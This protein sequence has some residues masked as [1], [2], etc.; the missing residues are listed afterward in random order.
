MDYREGYLK[1]RQRLLSMYDT[2]EVAK[3]DAWISSL[4]VDD[5]RASLSDL[6]PHCPLRP[7]MTVLDAGAGTG[8]LCIMLSLVPGLQITALE[9]CNAMLDRLRGKPEI[10]GIAVHQGF[11]D[12]LADRIHFSAGSF[13][14]IASRQL[15]NTLFDPLSAF[16][17]WH[18][19]L[20]HGGSVIVMDGLFDRESWPDPWSDLVDQLP[21]S[22]CRTMATVP[23]LLEKCGFSIEYVG[24]MERTNEMPSTRTKRYMVVARKPKQPV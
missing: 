9:P 14:V 18:Y 22:A 4:T 15:T 19:W 23:Y 21:L 16:E 13:D 11:C 17:N 24:L 1:F 6:L 3:Y 5:H 7:G 10:A 12:H 20:R 2:E 8:A